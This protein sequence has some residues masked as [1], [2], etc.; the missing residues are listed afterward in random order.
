MLLG[1]DVLSGVE[2][3]TSLS[4]GIIGLCYLFLHIQTLSFFFFKMCLE[5]AED[6]C[7]GIDKL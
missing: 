4:A 2:T 5:D 6:V 3:L 1:R 7:V